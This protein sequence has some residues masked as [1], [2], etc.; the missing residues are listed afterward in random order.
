MN[1]LTKTEDRKAD[2]GA[3]QVNYLTP[4]ANISETPE[5]YLLEAEMPGVGKGGLEV[6]I[7]NNELTILG[8]RSDEMLKGEVVYRES[9]AWDYKRVFELDP[10]IDSSKITAKMEQGILTLTLPKTERVKPRKIAVT[11]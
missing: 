8:R 2:N 7:D 3:R 11:D 9:R 6:T 10:E 5:G 4:A 1:T